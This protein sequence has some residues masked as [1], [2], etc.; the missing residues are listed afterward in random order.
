MQALLSLVYSAGIARATGF[1]A[2]L[3]KLLAAD[4][5][6][7]E[8]AVVECAA[9]LNDLCFGLETAAQLPAG[10][11]QDAVLA[12]LLNTYALNAVATDPFLRPL[13]PALPLS[14]ATVRYRVLAANGRPLRANG[15]LLAGGAT[16]EVPPIPALI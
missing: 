7:N 11:A 1:A 14:G 8:A 9:R 5:S 10:A 4:D 13:L 2:Q 12:Y 3:D 15:R 16:L 6:V